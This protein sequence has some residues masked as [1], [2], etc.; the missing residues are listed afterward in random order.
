MSMPW[1][2]LTPREKDA[3]VA[4]AMGWDLDL[5]GEVIERTVLDGPRRVIFNDDRSANVACPPI[6]P[7]TTDHSASHLVLDEIAR[8]GLIERYQDALIAVLDLDM[9]VFNSAIEVNTRNTPGV[10]G[11]TIIRDGH[12]FLWAF[13][14]ATP[15]QVC[16]AAVRVLEAK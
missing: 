13:S 12:A 6:P 1:S 10:P 14:Q 7:F 5:G 2:D 8:R 4:T 16:E 3:R 9:Q 11:N 15:D